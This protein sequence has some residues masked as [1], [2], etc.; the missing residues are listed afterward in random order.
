LD[1][2]DRYIQ[3]PIASGRVQDHFTIDEFDFLIGRHI[4]VK[5]IASLTFGFQFRLQDCDRL[6][7]L[8]RMAEWFD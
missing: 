1:D 6:R 8:R 4:V 3:M 2:I 7:K 5:L